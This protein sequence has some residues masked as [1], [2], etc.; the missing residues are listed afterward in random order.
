[1]TAASGLRGIWRADWFVGFLVATGVTVALLISDITTSLEWRLYDS[2]HAS[3]VDTP[4]DDVA[5]IAIDDRSIA[6]LGR[7]PWSRSLHAELTG[8]LSK[9]GARTIVQTILFFEPERD[10]GLAYIRQLRT[11]LEAE[12]PF[13]R[14]D[15]L[16]RSTLDAEIAL[17]SDRA[18]ADSFRAAGNVLLPTV[19]QWSKSQSP[20]L[21]KLPEFLERYSLPAPGAALL[22]ARKVQLP[23][24][25]LADAAAG[26][27]HLN[28]FSDRDGVLRSELLWLEAAGRAVPS[29]AVSAVAHYLQL[30]A[31]RMHFDG[32]GGFRLGDLRVPSDSRGLVL[33]RF[34]PDRN[35]HAAIPADS[36]VDVLKGHVPAARFRGKLVVIGATASGVGVHSPTPGHAVLSPAETT[37]HVISSL[38]KQHAIEQPAWGP[39]FT[40]IAVL[41]VF[42]YLAGWITRLSALAAAALTSSMLLVL[43]G[44]EYWLLSS[45]AVWVK[46]LLPALLLAAGHVILTTRRFWLVEMRKNAAVQESAEANRMMGLALQGQG[47]LDMAFDRFLR[48]PASPVLRDSLY[49]LALDFERKRQFNKALAVYDHIAVQ[50][51]AFRDVEVKRRSA[52]AMASGVPRGEEGRTVPSLALG[53]ETSQ[54]PTLGRYVLEAELGR[55]AMGVVYRGRDPTIGRVVAIKTLALAEEF[56]GHALADAR[57]RFFREAEAAGRLHH[58][59]IV[60]IFDAGEDHDLAYIAM[61]WVNGSDLERFTTPAT[62]LP[63]TDVLAIGVRVAKALDYAH[64]QQV[65]HRDI[66]PAN[67]LLDPVSHAVKVSDFGIARITDSS[68]TK[69]ALLLGTP[70]FMAPEQLAGQEVDGRSDLYALAV[71]LYQLLTGI[72]PFRGDSLAQLLYKIANDDPVDIRIERPDLTEELAVCLRRALAKKPEARFQTGADFARHLEKCLADMQCVEVSLLRPTLETTRVQTTIPLHRNVAA[73]PDIEL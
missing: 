14:Q 60:T 10:T 23:V 27:G 1:V 44:S 66:K 50:D 63:V 20:T 52:Q 47:Q 62:L 4:S 7:W 16:I 39:W 72:L 5:V 32:D 29:L 54:R 48:V 3:S 45:N 46:L 24:G 56:S 42:A 15:A 12:A 64:R 31:E 71:A 59:D 58:P 70:S 21:T 11:Q 53:N 35:G 33:P 22:S 68:K 51:P 18:L 19:F 37:A 73:A 36:F 57:S 49:L 6:E 2:V 41:S 30:P 65:V 34:Y 8:I 13:P 26:G 61:E 17:D 38:L 69:T 28:H 67:I 40:S 55:G 43:V 25:A 9:A